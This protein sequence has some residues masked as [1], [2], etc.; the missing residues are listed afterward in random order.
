MEKNRTYEIL[1]SETIDTPIDYMSLKKADFDGLDV[2][3]EDIIEVPKGKYLTETIID[4]I[5]SVESNTV[6]INSSVG[7][8]KSHL[9]IEIATRYFFKMNNRNEN[10]YTVIF[11][12]PY[13][14]LIKQYTTK[15]RVAMFKKSMKLIIPDYSN[16]QRVH[17]KYPIHVVTINC[18]LR[19]PGEDTI[20]QAENK[21]IYLDEI[22]KDCKLKNRKIILIFDEIHEGI[23]NFKQEL[24]FN[25]WKFRTNNVL[26][27][28]FIL[29][30]TFSEASKVVIKYLAEL[31]NKKLQILETKRMQN[32]DNISNLHLYL[33]KKNNYDFTADN[34]LLEFF[35]GII[36]KHSRINI[37]C[38]SKSFAINNTDDT[39]QSKLKKLI[40][41]KFE[42]I[43][44]C[45]SEDS[46]KGLYPKENFKNV[47]FNHAFRPDMCNIGTTFTTGISIEDEKSALV[48]MLPSNLA[49]SN[50][51]LGVFTD[52]IIPVIQS[53][54]RVRKKSNIYVIMPLPEKLIYISEV[55]DDNEKYFSVLSRIEVLKKCIEKRDS[56]KWYRDVLNMEQNQILKEQY[57]KMY[58]KIQPEI[59]YIKKLDRKN[60]PYLEYPTD[61]TFIMEKGDMYLSQRY[62]IFGKDL[63]AYM[64]WAALNNQFVN[65][66]IK[67]I[68]SIAARDI[69]IETG[70]INDKLYELFIEFYYNE[71]KK[72][73]VCDLKRYTEFCDFLFFNYLHL[74]GSEDTI[75]E[76]DK[77]FQ[78]HIMAFF[79]G[80]IK[81]NKRL[82]KKYLKFDGKH[83]SDTTFEVEDYLLC[84]ISNANQYDGEQ[85]TELIEAY[86]KL[87]EI[88]ILFIDK[89]VRV[90]DNGNKYIYMSFK[91]YESPFDEIEIKLILNTIQTVTEK[92]PYFKCFRTFQNIDFSNKGKSL[93]S[94]YSILKDTFFKTERKKQKESSG[95]A[96]RQGRTNRYYI[97]YIS[98]NS[99]PDKRTGINLLYEY[100]YVRDDNYDSEI[101]EIIH[102]DEYSTYEGTINVELTVEQ[103][104]EIERD[105]NIP[106]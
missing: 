30:A 91:K 66:K 104:K 53:L 21:Q 45:I 34:E 42:K 27:K 77:K 5:K 41:E 62:A 3:E 40:I 55:I 18:L 38:S 92:D 103:R 11:A 37:L 43:N 76:T 78:K 26:H 101:L 87:E 72:N 94:I 4:K 64:L 16:P 35:E 83:Y 46:Y 95:E 80:V 9:A 59:E 44:L 7:Q 20:E 32:K 71:C 15:I 8:G 96:V 84:C 69:N 97:D 63:S 39:K 100:D 99:L 13:K 50:F 67:S 56:S 89:L 85:P 28:T 81:G 88:R 1:D 74:D 48:I 17:G 90:S 54:A 79:Q 12:V 60:L 31:T 10:K 33:T 70:S 24:I 49:L 58:D 73:G 98:E 22:I 25:L 6:V 93:N 23:H 65:C 82:G 2:T 106:Q 47:T 51:K 36:N 61:D 86:K 75:K 102:T 19:N 68:S 57:K 52:G 29:S 105:N 14:S